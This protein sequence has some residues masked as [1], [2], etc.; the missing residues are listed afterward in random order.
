MHWDPSEGFWQGPLTGGAQ[1]RCS[2]CGAGDAVLAQR[3]KLGCRPLRGLCFGAFP[4][5]QALAESWRAWGS[6]SSG[7]AHRGRCFGL[8]HVSFI[9]WVL[10]KS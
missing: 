8:S 7:S 5:F 10:L 6:G 2:R 1:G 3:D 9:T 4:C